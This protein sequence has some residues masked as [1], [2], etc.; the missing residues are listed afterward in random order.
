M[1]PWLRGALVLAAVGMIP[2]CGS[3][4]DTFTL[5]VLPVPTTGTIL[6]VGPNNV[7]INV[8]PAAPDV[9]LSAIGL[10]NIGGDTIVGIDYRASDHQLFGFGRPSKTLYS[11]D[12]QTGECSPIGPFIATAIGTSFGLDVD[13]ATGRIRLL[14]DTNENL[15]LDPNGGPESVD[16]SLAFAGADSNV[17]KDPNI[18]ACAYVNGGGTLYAIDSTLDILVTVS[19]VATGT[20]NT[21]G[22]LGI[23]VSSAAGFDINAINQ[24]YAALEVGGVTSLY[25]IDLGT[26]APSLQGV[27]GTGGPIRGFTLVP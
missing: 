15:T 17:G 27:L 7:L 6:Y 8:S 26:G 9:I 1:R 13:P 14:G 18:V 19:P 16:T 20:L 23:D 22:A 5:N 10:K 11:I 4:G 24:G 21:V 2:A 12:P 25:L 3:K